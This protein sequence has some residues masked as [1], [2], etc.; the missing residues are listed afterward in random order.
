[1]E[2]IT[3]LMIT[4]AMRALN[5]SGKGNSQFA[6]VCEAMTKKITLGDLNTTQATTN[7]ASP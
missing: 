3:Q 2:F 7:I 4:K 1:M 5:V 6:A